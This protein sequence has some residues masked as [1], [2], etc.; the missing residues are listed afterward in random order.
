VRVVGVDSSLPAQ[1]LAAKHPR[2]RCS[3]RGQ[4]MTK[5]EKKR[6]SE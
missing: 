4:W 5:T 1:K 6:E 2:R 3:C